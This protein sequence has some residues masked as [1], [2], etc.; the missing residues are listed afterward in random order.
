VG[1]IS[2]GA[3]YLAG[4]GLVIPVLGVVALVDAVQSGAA[5]L[6]WVSPS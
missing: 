2:T 1:V 6:S 5:L 4:A 3:A